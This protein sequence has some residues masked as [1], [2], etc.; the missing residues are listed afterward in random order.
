MPT[1]TFFPTPDPS[2][3]LLQLQNAGEYV[4]LWDIGTNTVQLW[5]MT[6]VNSN[7]IQL[8]QVAF[9]LAIVASFAFLAV[10]RLQRISEER[11]LE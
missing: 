6:A 10:R 2:Q 3:V 11:E 7:F 1:P 4:S 5:N 9:V 8:I